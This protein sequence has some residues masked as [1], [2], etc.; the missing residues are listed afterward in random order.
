EDQQETGAA[1]VAGGRLA[2]PAAEAAKTRPRPQREQLRDKESGVQ[3]PRVVLGFHN[4]RNRGWKKA[5]V[6]FGAGRIYAGMPGTGSGAA[7]DGARRGGD[8]DV[9]GSEA[10]RAGSGS[11]GQRARVHRASSATL[12]GC[13]ESR[14]VVYCSGQSVGERLQRVVQQ[15]DEGGVCGPR[16]VRIADGGEGFGSG[17]QALLESGAVAQRDRIQDAGGIRR[18]TWAG[19]RYAPSAP[20]SITTQ[21][22]S[23]KHLYIKRGQAS[24][25]LRVPT[26]NIVIPTGAARSMPKHP[27]RSF[28]PQQPHSPCPNAQRCHSD[29]SGP[30]SS[31]ALF[32]GASGRVVEESCQPSSHIPQPRHSE[33]SLRSE[34]RFSIARC[35]CDEIS[36]LLDITAKHRGPASRTPAPTRFPQQ[37]L[38]LLAL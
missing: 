32:C 17:I 13:A 34:I 6:V 30:I 22:D 21:T 1:A 2:E 14:A 5:E 16:A 31:P 24:P 19:L 28:R 12:A 3:E 37:P 29:R 15:P 35:S 10:R 18:R 33:R 11:F 9:A 20:S 8:S 27:T 4:G 23:H 7:H 25:I 26:P 38:L 36:L